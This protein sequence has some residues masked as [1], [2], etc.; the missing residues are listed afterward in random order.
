MSNCCLALPIWAFAILSVIGLKFH[1]L[2]VKI[3]SVY[4]SC[5]CLCKIQRLP[6]FLGSLGHPFD[7][8]LIPDRLYFDKTAF[9]HHF[10][11]YLTRELWF[12]KEMSRFT[13]HE[14]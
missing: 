3:C 6:L 5:C 13:F 4:C 12:Y 1:T 8:R 14:S 9:W 11:T 10:R 7:V 2:K